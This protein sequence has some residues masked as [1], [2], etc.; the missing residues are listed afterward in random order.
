MNEQGD[1]STD[2]ASW[3]LLES[4]VKGDIEEPAYYFDPSNTD[5]L[6]ELDILLLTQGWRDFRW[7]YNG[8]EYPPEYG[9][10]IKGKVRKKF[11]DK[12]LKNST[13]TIGLFTKRKP[14]VRYLLADNTGYFSLTGLDFKGNATIIASVA[15][16][17]DKLKGWLVLD[18]SQYPSPKISRLENTARYFR[19]NNDKSYEK[20][21]PLYIQY[22]EYRTSLEK[23]YRLSDTIRPGEVKITAKRQTAVEKA[24][25]ESQHY[26]RSLW[27]DQEYEVTPISK[28]YVN[29]GKLL[30]Q[31][32]WIKPPKSFI[33]GTSNQ[34]SQVSDASGQSPMQ[35][36]LA[37]FGKQKTGPVNIQPIF[38]LDG[39]EVGWAGVEYI[40]IEWVARVDYVKGRNAELIWGVRGMNGVVSV[41][42]KPDLLDKTKPVY[43]SVTKIFSGFSEPRIYFSPKHHATLESDYKPDLR[44][45]LFWDPD[46]KLTERKDT[47]FVFYNSDNPGTIMIKAEGITDKGIPVTGTAEYRV[48]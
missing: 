3:F 7:K 19:L 47:S 9:F 40:P 42:L 8:L 18:S 12:P 39:N 20:S 11:S 4:D 13:V 17:K 33:P 14:I 24:R 36:A 16:E 46:I 45:T 28:T 34:N 32:F 44:N 25:S 6:K 38:M 30:E 48:K 2:I 31:R 10:T 21:M 37:E 15:D 35:S 26:L 41:I 29:V 43:H 27:V 1:Y 5:R 22:A 23:K